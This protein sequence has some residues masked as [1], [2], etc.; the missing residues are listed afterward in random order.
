MKFLNN[1]FTKACLVSVVTLS[2]GALSAQPAQQG[3]GGSGPGK[4]PAEAM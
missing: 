4:P 3:Q 1:L 2:C